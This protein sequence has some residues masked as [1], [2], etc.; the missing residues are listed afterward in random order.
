MK[1]VP[2]GRYFPGNSLLHTLDPRAKL[3]S[4]LILLVAIIIS[5]SMWGYLALT[6][7]VCAILS[8]AKLG[9]K[10]AARPLL[11]L[12]WFIVIVFVMNLF[13]YSPENAWV[14]WWIFKPSLLGALQGFSIVFRIVLLS[15]LS[16]A[17]MAT[18]SPIQMTSAL[19]SFLKPLSIFRIPTQEIA[20]IL[21]VAIQFILVLQEETETITLAQTAR[22]AK[23]DSK[24]LSEKAGSIMPLVIP[25]FLAA[26]SRADDLALAMESRGYR[27]AKY[28]TRRRS[29]RFS[30]RDF[31]AIIICLLLC[32]LQI[33]IWR[34]K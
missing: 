23:F 8:L 25:V 6:L 27:G 3:G 21:S 12:K 2:V 34:F 16:A 19:E 11:A 15:V 18:T 4:F 17:V 13:F 22:G 20:M 5:N 14:N 26:F 33:F 1:G 32:A 29:S 28:R 31:S 24:R 10:D 7:G 30:F 9:W